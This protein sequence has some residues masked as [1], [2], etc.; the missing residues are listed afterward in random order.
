LKTTTYLCDDSVAIVGSHEV[1][2]LARLRNLEMAA[3]DEV[4][5]KIAPGSSSTG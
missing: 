2:D 1:L 5:R 3:A 4:R